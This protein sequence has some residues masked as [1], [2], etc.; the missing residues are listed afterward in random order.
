LVGERESC[1]PLTAVRR[2]YLWDYLDVSAAFQCAV[3]PSP[4]PVGPPTAT[5]DDTEWRSHALWGWQSISTSGLV[6]RPGQSAAFTWSFDPNAAPSIDSVTLS[7]A[8][9]EGSADTLTLMTSVN[10]NAEP[11]RSISPGT[12]IEVVVNSE[13]MQRDAADGDVAVVEF[14]LV[15]SSGKPVDTRFSIKNYFVNTR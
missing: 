5:Y 1:V 7:L 11:S 9:D 13:T 2:A 3:A 8:L 14:S 12:P 4:I 10:G 6:S 15:D